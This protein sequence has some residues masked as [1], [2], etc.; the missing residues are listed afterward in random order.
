MSL[1]RCAARG[2]FVGGG[3]GGYVSERDRRS[4]EARR[5]RRWYN[6]ARWKR[7]RDAQLRDQP[8]CQMCLKR[9][10]VND[11]SRTMTGEAQAD[12]RRRHLVCDHITP[13][14]GDEQAFW[15]GPFQTLCPDHH[16]IVKQ[17]EDL[18]GYSKELGLDGWPIDPRHPAN[19]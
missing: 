4:E 12:P 7:I 5:Y 14:R 1:A 2:F 18:R 8:L 15:A 10:L 9:G 17:G 13:H 19:R 16:D 11:G 3:G 6:T